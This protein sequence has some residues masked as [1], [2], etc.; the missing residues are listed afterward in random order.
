MKLAELLFRQ[1]QKKMLLWKQQTA[2]ENQQTTIQGQIAAAQSAEQSKQQTEQVK[3]DIDLQKVKVQEDSAIKVSLSTMFT[4]LMKD[5]APIPAN[6]Q[7]LFNVWVE[8]TMIPLVAQNDQQKAAMIQQYQ[9]AQQ[10]QAGQMQQAPQQGQMPQQQQQPQQQS[11]QSQPPPQ[12][13]A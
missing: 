13:A 2:Q 3:G 11:I 1:G 10:E 5:G 8:N 6:M 12:V 7:P 4:S 9:Q